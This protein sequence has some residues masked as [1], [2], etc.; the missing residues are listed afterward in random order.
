VHSPNNL[1]ELKC[2]ERNLHFHHG[3]AKLKEQ[4]HKKLNGL[5]YPVYFGLTQNNTHTVHQ[6][7]TL[8]YEKTMKNCPISPNYVLDWLEWP[9]EPSHATVLLSLYSKKLPLD[10]FF[11]INFFVY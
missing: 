5:L 1:I 10:I 3:L 4:F 9:N 6:E 7:N 2:A 11:F 8:N